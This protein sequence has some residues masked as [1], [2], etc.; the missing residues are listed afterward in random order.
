MMAIKNISDICCKYFDNASMLKIIDVYDHPEAAVDAQI[1]AAPTLI[2]LQ[3]SPVRR[4]IGD[5]SDTSKVL[6]ALGIFPVK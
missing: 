4:L 6:L 5:L 1:I 2:K 3:P